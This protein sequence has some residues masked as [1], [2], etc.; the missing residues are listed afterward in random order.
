LDEPNSQLYGTVISAYC[1]DSATDDRE[2][3]QTYTKRIAGLVH[4]GGMLITAALRRS[5]GYLVGGKT[6]PSPDIDEN[7]LRAVLESCF[8]REN[9]T[10]EVCELAGSEAK[11]YASIMLARA[12]R[13]HDMRVSHAGK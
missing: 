6:F 9:I 12:I 8:R 2:L 1:A 13:R 10:I 3:W 4:P 11:G 7:D 5:R